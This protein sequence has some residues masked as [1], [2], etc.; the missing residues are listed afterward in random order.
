MMRLFSKVLQWLG[1]SRRQ[2]CRKVPILGVEGCGKS[3]LIFTLGHYVS[4]KGLGSVPL[5]HAELFADYL[6][7][8]AAGDPLPATMDYTGFSLD[9]GRIPEPGGGHTDVDL[10]LSSEDIPGQDFRDLVEELRSNP[11]LSAKS[12]GSAADIL[13]RFSE[14]LSECDGFLFVVDLVRDISPADFQADPIKHANRALAD[15]VKPIMTGIVLAAKMHASL[16]HKPV[17]FVFSKPDLHGLTD[18][19]LR[20]RF[21]MVMAIPLRQLEAAL[22]N[23]QL[24]SV[25][26]A[27]WGMDASVD[28]LGV[29]LLLSDLVHAV[30][31]VQEEAA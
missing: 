23:V 15:Q 21:E 20:Q 17:V 19:Q 31:A 11:N 16:A 22:M 1:F 29:D 24:Y 18:E 28:G 26:C 10:L 5:E 27:G 2:E 30:G 14:L 4:S 7:Y 25:Q 8:V 9:V 6:S 12:G 13:K 3:S